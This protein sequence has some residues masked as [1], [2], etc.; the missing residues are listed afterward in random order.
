M[1]KERDTR[2]TMATASG[3]ERKQNQR[4]LKFSF[5]SLIPPYPGFQMLFMRGFRF[6][7]SLKKC[8]RLRASAEHVSAWADKTKLPVAREK[9][10]V[11]GAM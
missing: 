8:S 7:S 9:E 4:Q 5:L 1:R 11:L 6:R 3:Q 10:G 2:G